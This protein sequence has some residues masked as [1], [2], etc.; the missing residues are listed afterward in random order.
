MYAP[1]VAAALQAELPLSYISHVTGHGLLKLMRPSRA[2]TYRVER[3]PSIPPVLSFLVEQAGLAPHAAYSTFNMGAGFALYCAAG[4]GERLV[5]L[6]HELGLSAL[7]AG[8]VE[9]GPRRVI[10]EPVDVC[11][12]GDELELSAGYG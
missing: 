11:F 1:L 5:G 9:D 7:L 6:A 3:L 8:H 12:E 4:A 10:V 2:L